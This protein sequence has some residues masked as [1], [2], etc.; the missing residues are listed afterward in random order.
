MHA[1]ALRPARAGVFRSLSVLILLSATACTSLRGR[2]DDALER[3]DYHSA[4]ALYSHLYD[5]NPSDPD[6]RERLT[7]SERG[8]LDQVLVRAEAARNAGNDEDSMRIALEVVELK[9]RMHPGSIDAP[10]AE[11]I[12]Q[13]LDA[14]SGKLRSA[15]REE[16]S[17][18]R[19]LAARARKKAMAS[20]LERK[21]LASLGPELD[22]EIAK[23]GAETCARSTRVAIDQP[24]ALE[25]VAAY[26]KAVGGAM[27]A[28][29]PRPYL[30]GGVTIAGNITGTP[31]SEQ[32]ELE[33]VVSDGVE[34][35]VWFSVGTQGRAAATVQ[36]AAVAQFSDERVTLT[37]PWTEQVPYT[38]MEHYQ[39]AIQIPYLDTENY[40]ES[41][42]YTAYEQHQ[43]PCHGGRD[44]CTVSR[45]VTRYRDEQRTREVS[46]TRTE[47]RDRVRPVTRYRDEPRVFR[48]PAT[49]HTGRYTWNFFVRLDVGSGQRPIEARGSAEETRS[50]NEHDAE[51]PAA[52]V[53][54]EHEAL[55]SAMAWRQQ[56]R[57]RI[58]REVKKSLDDAWT[59]SF[60]GGGLASIEEGARCAHARPQP[61]PAAVSARVEELF[62]DDPALVLALPRPGE[63]V[64]D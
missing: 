56:Q 29:K 60:C 61:A 30:V 33:R 47:Y 13:T 2:A 42:P 31:P 44:Y 26:C 12:K 6:V 16:T 7:R 62:G 48:Y 10:R 11:R 40:T 37:R 36:G 43:E 38:A 53:H 59:R 35:S 32:A 34:R 45:P 8:L 17:H 51:F 28:W 9:D 15:I 18:G 25:L 57:E 20:W 3:G 52:G 14:S 5:K 1:A 22:A 39:E 50:T 27:P 55:P 46:K 24:F 54:P 58:R 19:A 64:T 49:K 21:E 4:V 63:S 41:V 23:A